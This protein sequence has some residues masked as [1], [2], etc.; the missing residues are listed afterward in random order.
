MK[1]HIFRENLSLK[2]SDTKVL[3]DEAITE[4]QV[5]NGTI[6]V[7]MSKLLIKVLADIAIEGDIEK[8]VIYIYRQ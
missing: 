1:G 7:L 3:I 4:C 6:V 8:S 5:I 2:F